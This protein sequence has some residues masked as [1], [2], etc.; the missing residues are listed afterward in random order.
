MPVR[1]KT[2]PELYLKLVT[3]YTIRAWNYGL[4]TNRHGL[5][6][7]FYLK[8]CHPCFIILNNNAQARGKFI[9]LVAMQHTLAIFN[10]VQH[11]LSCDLCHFTK[12]YMYCIKAPLNA[13]HVTKTHLCTTCMM[14][15]L[16]INSSM[17]LTFLFHTAQKFVSL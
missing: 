17:Q 13:L 16:K 10:V 14:Y 7:G 12:L 9:M 15:I 4:K 1:K 3:L 6:S 11:A 8:N 2:E 5:N